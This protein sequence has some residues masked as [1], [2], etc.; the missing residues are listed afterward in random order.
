VDVSGELQLLGHPW[1]FLW[2]KIQFCF[3]KGRRW[4]SGVVLSLET[5]SWRSPFRLGWP[6][7]VS[8]LFM[9]VTLIRLMARTFFGPLCRSPRGYTGGALTLA[10]AAALCPP[11]HLAAASTT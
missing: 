1:R 11:S 2:L 4:C 8:W 3:P 9:S 7:S 5:L 10:A 6:R